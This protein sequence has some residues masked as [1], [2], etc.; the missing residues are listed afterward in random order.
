MVTAKEEL[1]RKKKPIGSGTMGK[2]KKPVK[3]PAK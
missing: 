2:S 3:R 1:K